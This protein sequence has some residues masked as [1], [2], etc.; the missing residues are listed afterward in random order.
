MRCYE[1]EPAV[2]FLTV[3]DLLF[4]KQFFETAKGSALEIVHEAL[5]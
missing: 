4:V 1:I 3:F 5:T 2:P